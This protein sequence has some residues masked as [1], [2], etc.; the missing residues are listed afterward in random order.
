[1]NEIIQENNAIKLTYNPWGVFFTFKD[2]A[3]RMVYVY[4]THLGCF[5]FEAFRSANIFKSCKGIIIFT[6]F[7]LDKKS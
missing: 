5:Q 7:T 6:P 1:M 4:T 3:L 2:F